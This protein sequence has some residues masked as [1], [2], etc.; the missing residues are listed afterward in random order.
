MPLAFN[1]GSIVGPCSVPSRRSVLEDKRL[2][3]SF[4]RLGAN[5]FE[6]RPDRSGDQDAHLARLRIRNLLPAPLS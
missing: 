6:R 1:A 5:R 2:A 3:D 4:L